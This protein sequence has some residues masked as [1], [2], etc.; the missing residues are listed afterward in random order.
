MK[1][2]CLPVSF[3]RE[4]IEGRM[5]VEA[6]ARMGA[7]LPLDAID[8]SILFL[9][10]RSPATVAAMRKGIEAAG[11]RVAML[12]TYPDFTHPDAGQRER[13]LALAEETVA[14]ADGLGAE[15][16]RVTAGQAHPE[17][18][19]EEGTRW[20]VEGLRRLA[21]RTRGSRVRL[22]YENHSKPGA[23][24]YTD[25][26]EPPEVFLAILRGTADAGLGVNFD[27][28]NAT[29]FSPDPVAL[30]E[31]CLD[32]VVCIHAADTAVRGA[33]KPV[34]LGTGLAP[35]A[36]IFRRLARAGW[37]NWICIEEASFQGQEGIAKATTF[38]R[39]AWEECRR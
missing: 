5:S 4:I 11:T 16:L 9:P 12:T 36:P 6:W 33:L 25:F 3:F 32:R 39:R 29:A 37:D 34:L 38:V 13:E 31:A 14:V 27:T 20:A 15:L 19:R 22:V 17:T 18:G 2:S 24:T 28:A 30:L 35:F 26:S 10:D 7:A 1:L 23:W 21:E 8:L